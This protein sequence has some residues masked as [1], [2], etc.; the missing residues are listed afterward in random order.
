MATT[1]HLYVGQ[2][3]N[4][5]DLNS[6]G[7]VSGVVLKLASNLFGKGYIVSTLTGF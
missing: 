2:D 3:D 6:V 7:K 5:A 1:I 4:L